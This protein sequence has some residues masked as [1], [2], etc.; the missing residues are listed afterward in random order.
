MGKRINGVSTETG[1]GGYE[2]TPA[3]QLTA[4]ITALA[5]TNTANSDFDFGVLSLPDGYYQISVSVVIKRA[6]TGDYRELR[7]AFSATLISGA[8]VLMGTPAAL[9]GAWNSAGIAATISVQATDNL[10][11]ALTNSST[12]TINGRVHISF[13]RQPLI[14]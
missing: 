11:V 13:G 4:A 6:T 2:S 9:T 14:A 10:R 5:N 12:E 3:P 1:A 7:F 8:L